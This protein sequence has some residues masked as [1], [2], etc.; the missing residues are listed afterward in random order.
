[1]VFK[2]LA[3]NVL[4]LSKKLLASCKDK[5]KVTAN[6]LVKNAFLVTADL[7]AKEWAPFAK[8]AMNAFVLASG[9]KHELSA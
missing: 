8:L 2:I 1:M 5:S 3:A 4:D 7:T 9:L 6:I